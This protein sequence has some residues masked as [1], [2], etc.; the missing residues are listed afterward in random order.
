MIHFL[1]KTCF[2]VVLLVCIIGFGILGH[3]NFFQSSNKNI[4]SN[5][6]AQSHAAAPEETVLELELAP[7]K[8]GS[9]NF[10]KYT[11]VENN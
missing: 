2:S 3:A 6:T 9:I 8:L 11:S 10:E 7:T 1:K 4:A 5:S